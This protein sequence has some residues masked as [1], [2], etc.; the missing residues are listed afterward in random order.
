MLNAGVGRAARISVLFAATVSLGFC[1]A[2]AASTPVHPALAAV[3]VSDVRLAASEALIMTGS[4][5]HTVDPAWVQMAIDD[6][7]KPTLGGQYTGVPVVTPEEFWPFGGLTDAFIDDSIVAGGVKL[8]AAVTDS[9]ARSAQSDDP[10]APIVVFGYSQ[11]AVI[12]TRFK[13]RLNESVAAGQSAPPVTF[14]VIGNPTRPNG[15]IYARFA[16]EKLPG[17]TMSG[18]APT[19]TPFHTI[20]IARQYDFFADFPQDPSNVLAVA[21]AVMGIV[22][23]HGYTSVTLDP[24][25]PRYNPG[26]VVQT[27]G[28]TTYYL[29]PAEHLPL[30][31][32]LWDAGV[33]PEQL[34]AIEP[35]LRAFIEKGYDRSIPFGQPTLAKSAPATDQA[36]V[37]ALATVVAMAA[38]AAVPGNPGA[39]V[40]ADASRPVQDRSRRKASTAN[41]ESRPAASASQA[42]GQGSGSGASTTR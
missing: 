31:Q 3:A 24:N 42:R 1:P 32:P 13:G 29:I 36:P 23:A 26:T 19:D 41:S 12:S 5:M 35:T 10:A 37:S 33:S 14:V 9:L 22:Y 39:G 21:N 25:D 28:D 15:G 34:G 40:P 11:S 17:W 30:L 20:D 6:F 2:A 7:I 4:T 27:Y 16:G 38:N 18:P 8:D